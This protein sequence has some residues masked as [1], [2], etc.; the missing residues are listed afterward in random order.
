LPLI[1]VSQVE[2]A[3]KRVSAKLAAVNARNPSAFHVLPSKREAFA[4][5]TDESG[6]GYG[7]DFVFIR[8]EMV[9]AG[10][11]M[12]PITSSVQVSGSTT[13]NYNR[14]WAAL[15]GKWQ[16]LNVH[17]RARLLSVDPE[18]MPAASETEFVYRLDERLTSVSS[19]RHDGKSAASVHERREDRAREPI[20]M[21]L[22]S[23]SPDPMCS[24][25]HRCWHP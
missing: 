15:R 7:E 16:F 3:C 22:R 11:A 24:R 1:A 6:A 4:W 9:K 23:V 12:Q 5:G 2:E 14:E 8:D 17:V 25:K 10:T 13:A 21:N 19:R 20:R 18:W